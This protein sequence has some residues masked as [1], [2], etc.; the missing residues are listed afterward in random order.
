[1]PELCDLLWEHVSKHT[2]KGGPSL[3][4]GVDDLTKFAMNELHWRVSDKVLEL[5]GRHTALLEKAI[6]TKTDNEITSNHEKA[7]AI[8]Y[9]SLDHHDSAMPTIDFEFDSALDACDEANVLMLIADGKL[10]LVPVTEAKEKMPTQLLPPHLDHNW[11]LATIHVQ[12]EDWVAPVCN[13]SRGLSLR[14]SKA[15]GPKQSK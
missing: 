5:A 14:Q 12:C 3:Q 6:D 9:E 7:L 11:C 1:M 10:V 15:R 8:I 13:I 4:L 2:Y